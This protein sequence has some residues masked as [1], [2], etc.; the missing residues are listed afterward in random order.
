MIQMIQQL[1]K[2]RAPAALLGIFFL[3]VAG[4]G[5]SPIPVPHSPLSV[6]DVSPDSGFAS[7][8]QDFADTGGRI[9][10]LVIDPTNDNI[11][12][13]GSEWAGVWKSVDAG[14]RWHQASIGLGSGMTANAHSLAVDPTNSQRLLYAVQDDDG[15][16][17]YQANSFPGPF[18]GLWFSLD[19]AGH[20]TH[21]GAVGCAGPPTIYSVIF[22]STRVVGA[23]V[24]E[25]PYVASTCGIW[26]T[27]D[28]ALASGWH[29]IVQQLPGSGNAVLATG[30]GSAVFAC[31]SADGKV[32]RS[33]DPGNG[34]VWQLGP[35]PIGVCNTI[36]VAPLGQ[37]RPSVLVVLTTFASGGSLTIQIVDF[38]NVLPFQNL[39]WPDLQHNDGSGVFGVF[40]ALRRSAGQFET[41]PGVKYDVYAGSGLNFYRYN[42]SSQL[43]D[44]LQEIHVDTWTMAFAST[45]DPAKGF[46]GEYAASDGGVY[47]TLE[48][49]PAALL[50]CVANSGVNSFGGSSAGLH[51]MWG[52]YVS[53]FS[54]PSSSC[55]V[56]NPCPVLYLPSADNDVWVY[57]SNFIFPSTWAILGDHLGDAG[58]VLTDPAVR[59]QALS[60]RGGGGGSGVCA[61]PF[62]LSV[63]RDG[64]PPTDLNSTAACTGLTSPIG[65]TGLPDQQTVTT[66]AAVPGETPSAG[67]YLVVSSPARDT[68]TA[69]QS[70]PCGNSPD[71]I[72]RTTGSSTP[73]P[74]P[75]DISPSAHFG[76]GE[77]RFVAA[78]GGTTVTTVYVL[79]ETDI[80]PCGT[81]GS[82]GSG[83][84]Y[85][86]FASPPTGQVVVWEP[87][88]GGFGSPT[89]IVCA[90]DLFVNPY[91]ASEIYVTDSDS[92]IKASFDGG[93]TWRVQTAMEEI[94]TNYGE[95]RLGINDGSDK[96]IF[97][98]ACG[99]EHM[100][101]SRENPNLRVASLYPGGLAFSRDGGQHWLPLK[102]TRGIP[103]IDLTELPQ[104]AWWDFEKN[105]ATG[106]GSIYMA[107]RGRS[108]QRV[109]GPFSTLESAGFLYCAACNPNGP[110]KPSQVVA[111]VP[112]LNGSVPLALGP[113]GLFHGN[114][115]FDSA[116]TTTLTYYF[117][118]DG[119]TTQTYE[120]TLTTNEI[121]AGVVTLSNAGVPAIAG[122]I[123]R[124]GKFV[125]FSGII[126]LDLRLTNTG[127]GLAQ[128]INIANLEFHTL[129]GVGTVT[130]DAVL[131][132]ALPISIASLGVGES[133]AVR[134][135]LNVPSGVDRFAIAERGTFYDGIGDPYLLAVGQ[136]MIPATATSVASSAN[137]SSSGQAVT[138][139]AMV[140]PDFG[141]TPA[142]V[143]TFW[144]GLSQLGTRALTA[145]KA[146]L[147]TS[148]L[149]VGTHAITAVY[150]GSANDAGSTSPIVSQTVK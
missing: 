144:N 15:T 25:V 113:D 125:F 20:W 45:Y 102:V 105:P 141:T 149:A 145:G 33:L 8:L 78:S 21:V 87:A 49:S 83:R 147:A 81:K 99:L 98:H 7:A 72:G 88:N 106:Q 133:A 18:G 69:N 43:W 95:F 77:V 16:T 40:T 82:T 48:G 23:G 63:S 100:A 42:P 52:L 60:T 30:G 97:G 22:A 56:T 55:V 62:R 57:R 6:T 67:T 50:D 51:A 10:S 136:T 85:K 66:V 137:P 32:Y 117:T 139:T 11:L 80:H 59:N 28:P 76:P 121:G 94:A 138:F 19:G 126:Y 27:T 104:S 127:S 61:V 70:P 54:Q 39:G 123:V 148:T 38:D 92:H 46:C 84:L 132:G 129:A 44:Q 12:Y 71:V 1:L 116:K 65:G 31:S 3:P 14:R 112:V 119:S 9:R 86:G 103:T 37:L 90:K 131:S 101:F 91:N 53:G 29:R 128:G 122:K 79:T 114:L 34:T 135:Y 109:D 142:G 73:L 17:R 110:A 140:T 89:G 150:G 108:I 75:V 143:V 4:S 58:Q 5:Q 47:Q 134:L 124:Q 96:S 64:Q 146:T 36:A 74:S 24:E 26:T 41:K 68:C 107:L 115:L 111:F 120:R 35:Q 118:A 13:A 130:Y 2:G 93:T